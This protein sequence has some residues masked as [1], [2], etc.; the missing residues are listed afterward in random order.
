[1]I[2]RPSQL[3]AGT[4]LSRIQLVLRPLRPGSTGALVALSLR[5]GVVVFAVYFGLLALTYFGFTMVPGGFIPNQDKGYLIINIQLPDSSSQHRTVAI[6]DRIQKIIAETPGTAHTV[7]IP[8]QSFV[9]NGVSSN[10]GSTFVILKPFSERRGPKL[11]S[12]AIAMHLRQRFAAEIQGAQILVFG[13]PAVDGLGMA[14]GFKIMLESTGNTDL[15]RWSA[16]HSTFADREQ[17]SPGSSACSAV[18]GHRLR[19][20]MS[21]WTGSSARP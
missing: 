21:T 19:N 10:F 4:V 16:R 1:M 6:M 3:A 8:G 12:E 20:C 15:R 14:G 5:L 17:D 9:M 7:D 18:F 11:N 2:I 13:P